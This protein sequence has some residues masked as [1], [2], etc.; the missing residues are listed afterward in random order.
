MEKLKE[1]NAEM[2]ES[3]MEKEKSQKR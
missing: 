1:E 2:R 3:G